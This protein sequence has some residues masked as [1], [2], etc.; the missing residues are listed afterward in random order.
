MSLEKRTF[1]T[2]DFFSKLCSDLRPAGLAFYQVAW[3]PSVKHVFH[4]ILGKP[5]VSLNSLMK[6]LFRLYDSFQE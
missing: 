1:R 2:F 5:C 6:S 4:N 3:D